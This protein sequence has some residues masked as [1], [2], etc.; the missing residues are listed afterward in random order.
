MW[1]WFEVNEERQDLPENEEEKIQ[2]I[3]NLASLKK[4]EKSTIILIQ[5]FE[6]LFEFIASQFFPGVRSTT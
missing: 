2:T 3:Y 5:L 4:I 1:S 6:S